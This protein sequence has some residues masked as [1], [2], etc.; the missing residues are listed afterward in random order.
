MKVL[1]LTIFPPEIGGP[2]TQA[3]DLCRALRS[4][5]HEPVVAAYDPVGGRVDSFEG[6]RV[7]RLRLDPLGGLP[8]VA[9]GRALGAFLRSFRRV[10]RVEE[11]D[12]VHCNSV[13]MHALSGGVVCSLDHRP[14]TV[15]FAS[16]YV[17]EWVNRDA[18]RVQTI[19][20]AH[21]FS[22]AARLLSVVE[23]LSIRS[24]TLVWAT[25]RY[26]EETLRSVLR[27]PRDR[28]RVIP[29]H[30]R[31]PRMRSAALDGPAAGP[32]YLVCGGRLV[33]HKCV[34]E[35]LDAFALLNRPRVVLRLF[36]YGGEAQERRLQAKVAALQLGDRVERFRDLDYEELLALMA[37]SHAYVSSSIEEGYP[38][39]VIE[40]MAMGL[41]ILAARRGAVPELVPD[42]VAGLLYE[43]GRPEELASK[44]RAILDNV[45]LRR[46]LGEAAV[47]R[48]QE[49]DLARGTE[50]YCRL[51][52]DAVASTK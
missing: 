10:C 51:F 23:R 7:Y 43:A 39:T 33:P 6:T 11:P 22:Q 26:R 13:G 42:E 34:D 41:P 30:I 25:S 37:E 50:R 14:C 29:N 36:G 48:A 21:A 9:A 35:T 18:V 45:D 52:E 17:W 47:V 38:I 32:I 16:D 19:P 40:A 49:L 27:V 46:S 20:E 2:A 8:P 24:F 15:K 1:I 5:G 28:I 3:V 4:C 44:M 31:L 12:V